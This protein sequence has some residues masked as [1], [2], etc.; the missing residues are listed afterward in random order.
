M[1]GYCEIL[2]L[3][4]SGH[5]KVNIFVNSLIEILIPY[6]SFKLAF[7]INI[8]QYQISGFNALILFYFTLY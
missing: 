5:P 2:I 3:L 1:A 7:V 6:N 4:V 8:A